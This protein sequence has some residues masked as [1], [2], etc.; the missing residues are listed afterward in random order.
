MAI[1]KS[2]RY[3]YTAPLMSV[4]TESEGKKKRRGSSFRA[5][6]TL[7][8]SMMSPLPDVNECQSPEGQQSRIPHCVRSSSALP[9]DPPLPSFS[10]SCLITT[11]P[12]CI[13]RMSSD[14]YLVVVSVADLD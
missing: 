9:L 3:A 5:S 7:W 14:T 2:E 13:V 12:P 11:A 4:E 10:S 8:T 1:Q 6:R